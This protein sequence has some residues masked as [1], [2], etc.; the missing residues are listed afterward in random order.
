M[1]WN[2]QA[3][4]CSRRAFRS[5]VSFAVVTVAACGVASAANI[6]VEPGGFFGC[7]STISAAVAVANSGDVIL[8]GQGTYNEQVTITK[9]LSLVAAPF[10]HPVINAKGLSN[11]IF[12]NGMATAPLPGVTGVIV[13]GFKVQNANYEG[14]L[15][16]NASD[17]ILLDNHVLNNNKSLVPSTGSCPGIPAFET[18]EGMDCGEGIHLMATD[19]A[20]VLRNV[21]ENNSGG[22]LI[23]SETGPSTSN[24]VKGNDVHDNPYACGITM[25][26]HPAANASGPIAGLPYPIS[27]NVIS[28]NQSH[29]NGLGLPGA[30]A[31][32]GIFA[33]FPGT[34]NT[35]NVIVGN[36]LYNNGL[37]GVTMHNHASAPPP[38]PGISL[39]DNV[40]IGNRIHGNAADTADAATSGPTGINIYSTAPVTG[41]MIEQN[42]FNDEAINIAF[43]VP[44]G[45]LNV[46]F[47][48]FNSNNVGV[49]NLGA[50]TVS[51]TENWWNCITGPGSHCSKTVGSGITTTPWLLLPFTLNLGY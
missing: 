16:A 26:G 37:P 47:N 28:H 39:N 27:H 34:S 12:I 21:V 8:V 43:K 33:P 7:K 17:V 6:C 4:L 46:H 13:Q 22:V 29:H 10:A 20:S 50:G 32:V 41:I 30:G 31:G 14:I 19:H 1:L 18:N 11:G 23:T 49:D 51:A 48:D 24:L 25:A 2:L 5:A 35:A 44:A 42:D 9:T 45:T 3:L 36:D 40:I 38:A 15:V